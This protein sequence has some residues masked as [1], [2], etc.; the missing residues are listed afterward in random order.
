MKTIVLNLFLAILTVNSVYN[1]RAQAD[2]NSLK[3]LKDQ[4]KKDGKGWTRG[5]GI[6]LDFAQLA[7]INP[8]VGA[9]DN[10]LGFGGLGNINANYK[11][12]DLF[13]ENR[14][15]IQLAIQRIGSSDKPFQKSLDRFLLGS[16]L[17]HKLNE[18]IAL[19]VEAEIETQLTPTYEGN[20]LNP[21][22]GQAKIAGFFAPATIRLSPGLD[23][24]LTEHLTLFYSPASLKLIYISNQNIANRGVFGTQKNDDGTFKKSDLQLGSTFKAI[25]NNKYFGDKLVVSSTLDLFSNYFRNPQ[26]ID[27]QWHNDISWNIWKGFALNLVVD[28]LYDD[29]ILVQVDRNNDNKYDAGELGKRATVIQALLL[30]YNLVF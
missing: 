6:G 17:G 30:K 19:A 9:G 11:K 27:F 16:K 4:T 24:K 5:A 1:L 23:Y 13:W 15:S 21:D 26:N 25:Y 3:E 8:R 10:K 12:A 29:D 2:D 22:T 18:K 28:V 7:L 14:A 20:I